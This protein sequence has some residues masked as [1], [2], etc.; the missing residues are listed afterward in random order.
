MSGGVEPWCGCRQRWPCCR[1]CEAQDDQRCEPRAQ[2]EH[3]GR[4]AATDRAFRPGNTRSLIVGEDWSRFRLRIAKISQNRAEIDHL[5][6]YGGP[7]RGRDELR[8]GSDSGEIDD[9]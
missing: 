9:T 4:Y 6:N 7:G 2:S 1:A 8:F 3:G 5:R